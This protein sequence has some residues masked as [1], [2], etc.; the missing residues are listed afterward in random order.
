[1]WDV[2][3]SCVLLKVKSFFL[4]FARY[5]KM[6]FEKQSKTMA[7]SVFIAISVYLLHFETNK[8]FS[9]SIFE[10]GDMVYL[11]SSGING[12]PKSTFKYMK[13]YDPMV[14]KFL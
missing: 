2:G 6:H 3:C 9:L 5:K 4:G 8:Y 1:M 10:H 11:K 7:V 14:I 12:L 13:W